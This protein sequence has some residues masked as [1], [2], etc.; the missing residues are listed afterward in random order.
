MRMESGYVLTADSVEAIE[1]IACLWE[2]ECEIESCS[3]EGYATDVFEVM[4][5]VAFLPSGMLLWRI[6]VATL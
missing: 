2:E 3:F 5:K 4:E 6:K 1:E